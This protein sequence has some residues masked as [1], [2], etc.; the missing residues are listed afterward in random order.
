MSFVQKHVGYQSNGYERLHKLNIF[1][2]F[3]PDFRVL[4]AKYP[5]SF[6]KIVQYNIKNDTFWIDWKDVDVVQQYTK[7]LFE[8]YFDIVDI[9]LS[10]DRLC[11]AL[12][13]RLNYICWINDL[14]STIPQY[15]LSKPSDNM[16][17]QC[18]T[19]R[20]LDIGVGGS[21]VYPLLGTSFNKQLKKITTLDNNALLRPRFLWKFYGTDV[22]LRA[23][24]LAQ[25]NVTKNNLLDNISLI[26]VSSSDKL[27]LMIVKQLTNCLSSSLSSSSSECSFDCSHTCVQGLYEIFRSNIKD[28]FTEIEQSSDDKVEQ[29]SLQPVRGPIRAWFSANK[30]HGEE[31]NTTLEPY[32]RKCEGQFANINHFIAVMPLQF[33]FQ[34]QFC[35]TNPPFYALD[36]Q[37]SVESNPNPNTVCT[38]NNQEMYTAG[39][40]V[41][42]IIGMIMDS[43]VLRETVAWYTA[44]VG[45]KSSLATCLKFV[46]TLRDLYGDIAPSYVHTT[47]F[48]QGS[49][50]RWGLAW[51]FLSGIKSGTGITDDECFQS[52]PICRVVDIRHVKDGLIVCNNRNVDAVVHF[53]ISLVD[54]V[55]TITGHEKSLL[56]V[57]IPKNLDKNFACFAELARDR[58]L[59]AGCDIVMKQRCVDELE[60]LFVPIH[61]E[62]FPDTD[63][64]VDNCCLSYVGS[65]HVRVPFY[66]GE[67]NE[68][69]C[70]L[71]DNCVILVMQNSSSVSKPLLKKQR[72]NYSS[73]ANTIDLNCRLT[74]VQFE[75]KICL[76]SAVNSHLNDSS[77]SGSMQLSINLK[78]SLNIAPGPAANCVP[79]G[80]DTTGST[81]PNIYQIAQD[82]RKKVFNFVMD[83][84]KADFLRSNRRWRKLL[85]A[86]TSTSTSCKDVS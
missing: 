74:V 62:L 71:T 23:L 61:W 32:L 19:V 21:C 85:A 26:H 65:C 73:T 35:M 2:H 42:F 67:S 84:I 60:A 18:M 70:Q 33:Q 80:K 24:E 49:T 46:R 50:T 58:F 47:Q 16:D 44:M 15:I 86:S 12:P 69:V 72:L 51:S 20:G 1:K 13:N 28:S 4:A 63:E 45:K 9:T 76:N 17:D 52:N 56:T 83:K 11:P 14:L 43:V 66:E 7:V 29:S 25:L 55:S 10:N 27:Q 36:E 41:A 64:D 53:N 40:E 3:P 48:V 5:S 37:E 78:E 30:A 31:Q 54:F 39:G 57:D 34:F 82:D 6:G 75:C 38:G 22:D 59:K 77:G 68:F 8:E 81:T 79:T